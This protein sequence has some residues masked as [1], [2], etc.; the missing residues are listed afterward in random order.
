MNEWN[1]K[2]RETFDDH[3]LD[4]GTHFFNLKLEE[5]TSDFIFIN[6]HY[7]KKLALKYH[8]D[9]CNDTSNNFVEIK[10]AYEYF[11][12]RQENN[13]IHIKSIFK[14]EHF[15]EEFYRRQREINLTGVKDEKEFKEFKKLYLFFKFQLN[16]SL[17]RPL[18]EEG[19]KPFK[20]FRDV[21][22]KGFL[23]RYTDAYIKS[24]SLDKKKPKFVGYFKTREEGEEF[25]TSLEYLSPV[26]R[27]LKVEEWKRNKKKT[28]NV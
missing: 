10:E 27:I 7:K 8:P 9:K 4:V 14:N 23:V 13:R 11:R 16:L 3:I 25:L 5:P 20:V 15:L 2:V 28:I 18:K 6:H 12:E 17:S 26:E 19:F 21:R 1:E 24:I 22:Y